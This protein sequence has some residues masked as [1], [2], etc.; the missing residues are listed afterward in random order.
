M[1]AEAA[2]NEMKNLEFMIT[3]DQRGA[4]MSEKSAPMEMK[5]EKLKKKIVKLEETT[6]EEIC[7]SMWEA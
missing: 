6:K 5:I 7:D 4:I 3:W 1:V 2:E